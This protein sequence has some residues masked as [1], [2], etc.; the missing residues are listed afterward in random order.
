MGLQKIFDKYKDELNKIVEN[1]NTDLF[2]VDT[3]SR[4]TKLIDALE[5]FSLRSGKQENFDRV[6]KEISLLIVTIH[7]LQI[8]FKNKE[9]D[10]MVED[11]I[12]MLCNKGGCSV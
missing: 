2:I 1:N 3:V 11:S 12:K 5:A 6:C 8:K 7:L 10:N 9:F 4:I